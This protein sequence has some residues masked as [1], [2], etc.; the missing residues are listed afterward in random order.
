MNDDYDGDYD[1]DDDNGYDD[2]DNDDDYDGDDDADNDDDDDDVDDEDNPPPAP[3]PTTH[4]YP[5]PAITARSITR[6]IP[7]VAIIPDVHGLIGLSA[8]SVVWL[9]LVYAEWPWSPSRR[10]GP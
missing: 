2:V 1:N 5:Y 9:N 10:R 6:I 8:R 3:T 4:L 7:T